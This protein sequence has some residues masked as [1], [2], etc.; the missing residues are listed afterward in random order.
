MP[1]SLLGPKEG[2]ETAEKGANIKRGR[3]YDSGGYSNSLGSLCR[4]CLRM[5]DEM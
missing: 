5:G 3:V 4:T 1:D 2:G